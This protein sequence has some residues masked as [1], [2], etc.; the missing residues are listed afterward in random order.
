[1]AEEKTTVV[2]ALT[3]LI[4]RFESIQ[5][6]DLP[7]AIIRYVGKHSDLVS[8][9]RHFLTRGLVS[10]LYNPNNNIYFFVLG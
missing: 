3:Q 9:I 10:N 8:E 6:S 4:E 1:M 2:Y 5:A 7:A